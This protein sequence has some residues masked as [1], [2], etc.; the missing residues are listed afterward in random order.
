[1]AHSAYN[2]DDLE[3]RY[4]STNSDY[5][6]EAYG[7]CAFIRS[8]QKTKAYANIVRIGL[9]LLMEEDPHVFH[10]SSDLHGRKLDSVATKKWK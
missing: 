3:A 7:L 6:R 5:A 8:S 9:G 2:N 4:S 10:S 1:L